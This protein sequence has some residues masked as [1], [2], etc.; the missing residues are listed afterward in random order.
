[1]SIQQ[2]C[3]HGCG[4]E[5]TY[6]TK[7]GKH[8]CKP[9]HRSCPSVLSKGYHTNQEKYGGKMPAVSSA[10]RSKMQETTLEKYG[11]VNASS[12][13][14]VKERRKQLAMDKYGVDNVSKAQ[15]VKS[16]I[17]SKVKARWAEVYKDKDFSVEG[18]TRQ[19]YTRKAGQHADTQYRRNKHWLDPENKRGKQW[20]VDHIYSVT[21]GFLNKVPIDVISDITNLRL[22]SDK[23]NYAKNRNSHKSIDQ[24]YEDFNNK[25]DQK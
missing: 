1:M 13:D 7:N 21:D 9:H 19:A 22:I 23:E 24:L 17:S 5:A 8:Q 16:V 25:A 10:V 4:Q 11:V 12:S 15:S 20:H 3:H 2:L 14:V 18:L 6:V